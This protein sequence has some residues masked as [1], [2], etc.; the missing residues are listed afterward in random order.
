M[1]SDV[2]YIPAIPYGYY[3]IT[4]FDD[5]LGAT[6]WVDLWV[7]DDST[8][9]NN[10]RQLAPFHDEVLGRWYYIW[11]TYEGSLVFYSPLSEIGTTVVIFRAD[12]TKLPNAKAV[13]PFNVAEYF[14]S[15]AFE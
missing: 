14:R 10:W 4:I 9:S 15:L 6:D 13:E 7:V 11:Y 3:E 1:P 2:T 5:R 12:T 8:G